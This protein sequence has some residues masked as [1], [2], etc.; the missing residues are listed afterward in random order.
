MYSASRFASPALKVTHRL[1]GPCEVLA[2]AE[3]LTRP[4]PDDQMPPR[5]KETP[6]SLHAALEMDGGSLLDVIGVA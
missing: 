3:A 2:A 4:S 1:S 6:H 5:P